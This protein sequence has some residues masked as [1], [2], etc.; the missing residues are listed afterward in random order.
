MAFAVALLLAPPTP[1]P[2][3]RA[4]SMRAPGR[5]YYFIADSEPERRE[6][7]QELNEVRDGGEIPMPPLRP[8]L[9]TRDDLVRLLE[10]RAIHFGYM[11]KLSGLVRTWKRRLFVLSNEGKMNRLV[12]CLPGAAFTQAPRMGS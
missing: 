8:T 7:C 9:T 12:Q 11:H 4:F 5:L 10:G 6:W 1:F 2:H 3:Y